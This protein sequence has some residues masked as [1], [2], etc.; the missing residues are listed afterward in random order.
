MIYEFIILFL[1]ILFVILFIFFF[2]KI[3][4]Q[5]N[6]KEYD[7]LSDIKGNGK[8]MNYCLDGCVRG[9]CEKNKSPDS[10]KFDFQCQYC[11]DKNTN[12]FYVDFN[13]KNEKELLPLYEEESNMSIDQKNMLNDNIEK[14][15]KYI[16]DLNKKI[17]YMNS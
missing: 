6:M 5:D 2:A 10:C 9:A 13:N 17:K 14:N 3:I 11:Q 16:E 1:T 4:N 15:N 12:M 7:V 8:N